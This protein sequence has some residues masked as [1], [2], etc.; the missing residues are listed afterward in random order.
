MALTINY[1]L[2]LNGKLLVATLRD[3]LEQTRTRAREIGCEYVG[4]IEK[5]KYDREELWRWLYHGPGQGRWQRWRPVRPTRGY[6]VGIC[7]GEGCDIALFGLCRYP[8]LIHDVPVSRST[9]IES[10]WIMR[11]CCTTQY[12]AD[13]GWEHFLRCHKQVLSLLEFW[14]HLGATVEVRDEGGYWDTQSEDGLRDVLN[15]YHRLIA[16]CAGAMKDAAEATGSGLRVEA[17]IFNRPDFEHLEHEG[18]QE[19]RRQFKT[20]TPS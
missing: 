19:V 2:S 3:F 8:H 6:V 16:M 15:Q 20:V 17:P 7:P 18:M 13:F 11:H 12:A 10:D 1:E 14:Q 9:E 5:V 4:A